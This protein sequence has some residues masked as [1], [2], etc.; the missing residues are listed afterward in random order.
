[1]SEWGDIAQAFSEED[2]ALDE[3]VR[4]IRLRRDGNDP[5]RTEMGFLLTITVPSRMSTEDV[6]R[7]LLSSIGFGKPDLS[8]LWDVAARLP[9]DVVIDQEGRL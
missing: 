9:E 6:R 4:A 7:D 5:T 3:L 2:D 8:I 1:M